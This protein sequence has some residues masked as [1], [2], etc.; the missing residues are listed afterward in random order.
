M[1]LSKRSNGI[2]YVVF[3]KSNGK[4]AAISTKSKRKKDA[5]KFLRTFKEDLPKIESKKEKLTLQQFKFRFYR[6]SE[7]YHTWKT[8]LAYK[9][10]F[11]CLH[12]YFGNILISDLT[13]QKIEEYIQYR[14]KN[15]SLYGARKDLINIKAFLNWAVEQIILESN[16][17]QKIPRVKPPEKLP[18]YYSREEFDKLVKAIDCDLMKDLTILAVNTGMRQKELISLRYSMIDFKSNLIKLDNSTHITKSKKVRTIPIND[19]ARELLLQRN[20]KSKNGYVFE[21][22]GEPIKQDY[23]I[24]NFKKYVIKAGINDKLN[25]HSL[26]HSFASWLVQKGTSI[27]VVSKLL[28]HSDIKTTEIYAHLENSVLSDAVNNLN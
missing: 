3:T 16:P 13:K 25:F 28:G 19:K 24:H 18:K 9:S 20:E 22:D 2:Y 8:T 4:R 7:A 21:K 6:Y 5:L 10:T 12:K 17:A 11:N 23:V 27:Y 15:V 14:I 1:F 26:R